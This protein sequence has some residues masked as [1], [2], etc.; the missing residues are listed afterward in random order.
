MCDRTKSRLFFNLELLGPKFYIPGILNPFTQRV[1][2]S[3]YFSCLEMKCRP[4]SSLVRLV[5]AVWNSFDAWFFL[6]EKRML[7][8]CVRLVDAVILVRWY[9][10][11][12]CECVNALACN[13]C[14][15]SVL[16]IIVLVCWSAG[17]DV[18]M[19][20]CWWLWWCVQN[21]TCWCWCWCADWWLCWCVDVLM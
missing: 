15:C 4:K 16:M 19:L 11:C 6:I 17:V 2:W 5:A 21:C 8:A 18:L 9:V 12:T 3:S 13:V 7:A 1:G 10:D 20:M 14:W